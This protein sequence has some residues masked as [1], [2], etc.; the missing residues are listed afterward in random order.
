MKQRIKHKKKELTEVNSFLV[1]PTGFKP[2]TF[3]SVVR[4][5]I[6]LSYGAIVAE[7]RVQSYDIFPNY[8]NFLQLFLQLFYNTLNLSNKIFT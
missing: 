3:A 2:V 7:L 5:S 1:T 8:Q 6:Q 4:C